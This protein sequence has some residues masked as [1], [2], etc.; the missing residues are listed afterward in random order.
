MTRATADTV[1]PACR[2]SGNDRPLLLT[3]ALGPPAVGQRPEAICAHGE[4][5]SLSRTIA[6]IAADILR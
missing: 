3:R 6:A 1:V 4:S 2:V 5:T